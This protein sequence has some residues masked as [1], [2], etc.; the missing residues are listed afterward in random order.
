M[1]KQTG[2]AT[3]VA[4]RTAL[5]S[6]PVLIKEYNVSK[7]RN[8]I[9]VLQVLRKM[10]SRLFMVPCEY[11][12]NRLAAISQQALS[13]QMEYREICREAVGSNH[14]STSLLRNK[15]TLSTRQSPASNVSFLK[16]DVL[17]FIESFLQV[18]RDVCCGDQ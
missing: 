18:A 2:M 5:F 3:V 4:I 17:F 11:R 12:L 7:Q 14:C 8:T 9:M 15:A 6:V 16:Y 1:M 10:C 13:M